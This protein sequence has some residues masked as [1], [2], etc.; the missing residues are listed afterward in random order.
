VEPHGAEQKPHAPPPSLWPV[1]FAVGVVVLLAGV[2]VGWTIAAL[3]AILTVLFGFLWVRDVVTEDHTAV[4]APE[5]ERREPVRPG[6]ARPALE[7]GAAMPP[8]TQTEA[9]TYS[10][11]GFLTLGTIGLGGAIGGLVTVP[12]LGF[13]I[14]PAF[15][16]DRPAEIDIGAVADFEQGQWLIVT[17]LQHPAEGEVSRR[18]AYVRSN[19]EVDGQPSFTILSNRCVHLGC[20]VQPNGPIQEDARQE[21]QI[22]DTVVSRIPT[23]P[24]GFGC[25]CHG[26]QYSIEGNRT[27]GPPVRA[28]DRYEYSIRGGRL[29]LGE[30]FSVGEVEGEGAEARIAKYRQAPPGVH[31][32]GIE[33]WLYPLPVPRG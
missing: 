18:T 27:A 15:R 33:S 29:L 30:P 24:A 6:E 7:G 5:P 13:T 16:S 22:A 9:E 1:G 10:R 32:D 28:L 26:G 20:P 23:A 11:S 14:V 8:A 21:E 12:V 2:V 3:G 25:P 4:P 17:F 19:G 31:V